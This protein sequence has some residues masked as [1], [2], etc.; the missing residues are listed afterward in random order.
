MEREETRIIRALADAL[1]EKYKILTMLYYSLEMS[2]PE[3][4]A[5][6]KIPEGTVKSRLFK[7]R[8]LIKKGLEEND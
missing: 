2:V 5:A 7:A 6:L 4:A 8:K 3:I 1:P